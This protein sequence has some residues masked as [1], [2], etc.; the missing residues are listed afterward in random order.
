ML[1]A[2]VFGAGLIQDH[3]KGRIGTLFFN[4]DHE[5]EVAPRR[6]ASVR[7]FESAF[8]FPV[9]VFYHPSEICLKDL[10]LPTDDKSIRTGLF[11][12]NVSESRIRIFLVPASLFLHFLNACG[13]QPGLGITTFAAA[14]RQE[15]QDENRQT[16]SFHLVLCHVRLCD[17]TVSLYSLIRKRKFFSI[18]KQSSTKSH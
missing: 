12:G 6:G 1:A 9:P 16:E 7:H 14:R 4:L 2:P 10:P 13:V 5:L 15:K 17:I 11:D 18:L 8:K 3:R